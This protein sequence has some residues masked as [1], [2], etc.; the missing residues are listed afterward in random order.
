MKKSLSLILFVIASLCMNAGVTDT[1]KVMQYNLLNY[2]NYTDYCPQD[3]NNVSDKNR[4]IRTILTAY[5]PDIFTVCEMG[6]ATN[7]PSDFVNNNLNINGI[8]YWKASSGSNTSNSYLTNAAF[9]NS[10]KMVLRK[11]SLAQTYI[12]DVDIYS[13]YLKN[14]LLASGDTVNLVCII[15]HLKAGYGSDNE[16]K[17]HTMCRNIMNNINNSYRNCNVLIMGDFNLYSSAEAAYQTLTDKNSYPTTY[18]I[19]P[20]YPYGVG[21]WNGNPDYAEYHTQS[22]DRQGNGCRS[23]GGLDD[24]FD[25]I[26]MSQNIYGG[27]DKVQ[28]INGSY[29]AIGQDGDRFNQSIN[30]P[31][32]QDVPA[33]VANA[34]F[35]NSDHL[36]VKMELLVTQ[37]TDIE[38]LDDNKLCFDIYP[39]P[40]KEKINIRFFQNNHGK[41]DIRLFNSLGQ[42]VYVNSFPVDEGVEEIVIPVNNLHKGVYFL[43]ITNGDGKKEVVKVVL[44]V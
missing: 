2:G 42:T 31:A 40:A 19:D 8:T 44:G 14:D 43:E 30:S 17:R 20:V 16:D 1:I 21:E 26:M 39:N 38:E 18:F 9:Y 15:A 5:Y 12:R 27:T 3:I 35:N 11:H 28:Y 41:A 25:F 13:F 22:V 7:L 6:K 4:Y 36:P 37:N 10:E 29:H 34:L 33:D 24:R 23:G 32:N